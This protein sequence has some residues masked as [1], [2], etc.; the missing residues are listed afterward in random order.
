MDDDYKLYAAPTWWRENKDKVWGAIFISCLLVASFSPNN[1]ERQ[2]AQIGLA[3]YSDVER[4][5]PLG[6][7]DATSAAVS[8]PYTPCPKTKRGKWLRA[9]IAQQTRDGYHIH[10]VYEGDQLTTRD[11]VVL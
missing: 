5:A 6:S 7:R 8:A 4:P 2:T 1:A 9:E 10:C 11:E 3:P